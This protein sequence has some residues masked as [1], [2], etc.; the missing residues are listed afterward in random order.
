VGRLV[1]TTVT[2]ITIT[3]EVASSVV[4]RP[5]NAKTTSNTAS[6]GITTDTFSINDEV[7][8]ERALELSAIIDGT[9][10]IGVLLVTPEVVVV[11]LHT[12][13][14]GI[15]AKSTSALAV[16]GSIDVL[17]EGA[18]VLATVQ[19]ITIT[20]NPSRLASELALTGKLMTRFTI[21][22][23]NTS[24]MESGIR[25]VSTAVDLVTLLVVNGGLTSGL[26]ELVI[27][28]AERNLFE[29]TI[30]I[31]LA[32]PNTTEVITMSIIKFAFDSVNTLSIIERVDTVKGV[33]IDALTA[34]AASELITGL[35]LTTIHRVKIAILPALWN[36]TDKVTLAIVLRTGDPSV[37][38][39]GGKMRAIEVMAMFGTGISRERI[40][41]CSAQVNIE[42][43]C[44]GNSQEVT[45]RATTRVIAASELL[46]IEE[47]D[48]RVNSSGLNVNN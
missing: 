27:V 15:V 23:L 32:L 4:A 43:K 33:A 41:W 42:V 25:I 30:S 1:L 13:I 19:S 8:R 18:I 36:I 26:P 40:I 12:L 34:T 10:S 38:G 16:V 46:I 31:A 35:S 24:N 28:N 37:N 22:R 20:V 2:R 47:S 9:V 44:H 5:A 48:L 7:T 6:L 17:T 21:A 11:T 3:I 14:E 45:A 39:L 29:R